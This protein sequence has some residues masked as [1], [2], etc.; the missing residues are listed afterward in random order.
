[1]NRHNLLHLFENKNIRIFV[2]LLVA[3]FF[4]LFVWMSTDNE[5]EKLITNVPVNFEYSSSTY[6]NASLDIENYED[7]TVDI[8]VKGPTTTVNSLKADDFTVYPNTNNV[9]K[10]GKEVLE[11]IAL[12]TNLQADFEILSI[13]KQSID[14]TFYKMISKKFTVTPEIGNLNI[15]EGYLLSSQNAVPS[16][17]T[18]TGPEDIINKISTVKAIIENNDTQELS[19]STIISGVGIELL[20]DRHNVI[21]DD[22]LVYDT[23]NVEVNINILQRAKLNLT[24]ETINPPNGVAVED[25]H[26]ELSKKTIEVGIPTN[27]VGEISEIHLGYINLQTQDLDKDVVFT[28]NDK[29]PNGYVNIE[30]IED[31][32]VSF[33]TKNFVTK[34]VNV[35]NLKV[36]NIP[37]E[38]DISIAQDNIWVLLYGLDENLE[39]ITGEKVVAQVDA[40]KIQMISGQS[41]VVAKIIVTSGKNVFVTGDYEI[42][43]DIEKVIE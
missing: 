6:K 35:S 39:K 25:L 4:T 17:I 23:N 41:S 27:R 32:T 42:L 12:K 20:D 28:I 14:I 13:S 43:V 18:I 9:T 1:M 21:N 7:I 36:I 34:G 15:K 38:Y 5:K 33:N 11:L 24:Y 29:L 30:K 19:A 2:S 37:A 31:V 40:S 8:M 16:E 26:S 10:P 3:I 22:L